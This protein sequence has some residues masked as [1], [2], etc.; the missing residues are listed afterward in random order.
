MFCVDDIHDMMQTATFI[1]K[2]IRF[3]KLYIY[4]TLKQIV[5]NSHHWLK[6]CCYFELDEMLKQTVK[7]VKQTISTSNTLSKVYVFT[8]TPALND[9]C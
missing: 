8:F 5:S 6:Q 3:Y 1:I 7:T 4:F 9:L 2:Y